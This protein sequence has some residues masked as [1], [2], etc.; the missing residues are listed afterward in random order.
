MGR[1]WP[2]VLAF[3]ALGC[4]T[5]GGPTPNVAEAPS[6]AEAPDVAKLLIAS[7]RARGRPEPDPP[8]ECVDA[9]P[10]EREPK[11]PAASPTSAE[12]KAA[13][14]SV[15]PQLAVCTASLAKRGAVY[16]A[17]QG[18][19]GNT[20]GEVSVEESSVEDCRVVE[21]VKR[22]FRA[23]TFPAVEGSPKT[24]V[25]GIGRGI[26]LE[27]RTAPRPASPVEWDKEGTTNLCV[28]APKKTS[29]PSGRLR[30]EQIQAVVRSNYDAFRKCYDAGLAHK[31]D[32]QG[33]V[34]VRFVID[35]EGSV[36]N[37]SV[38]GNEL[39]DCDVTACVRD[40]FKKLTF[41]KPEGGNVTI[42]YPI[43]LEPS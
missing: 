2:L 29:T 25:Y 43:T 24:A 7:R 28:D 21:C 6:E 14:D 41:P 27:P 40:E 1:E 37:A 18:T 13:F 10:G 17:V 12:F 22:V 15:Y 34:S 20:P 3:V 19:A 31:P 30:P 32:L 36:S 4:E 35:A 23:M 26:A 38:A 16:V 33:R 5:Y 9:P 39:P 11:A 42:V 8:L